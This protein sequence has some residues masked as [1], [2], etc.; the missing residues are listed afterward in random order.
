MRTAPSAPIQPTSGPLSARPITIT[1]SPMSSASHID[2]TA[3][4]AA[5]RSSPA[6]SSLLTAAVV[7]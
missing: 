4:W 7:P 5:S 6:P 2:W 1:P 3:W